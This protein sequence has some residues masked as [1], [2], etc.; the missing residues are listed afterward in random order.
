[1]ES[2]SIK[3]T[4]TKKNIKIII[5]GNI[6]TLPLDYNFTHTNENSFYNADVILDLFSKVESI[7]VKIDD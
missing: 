6:Q 7:L 5:N 4:R 1:M 3:I 2:L